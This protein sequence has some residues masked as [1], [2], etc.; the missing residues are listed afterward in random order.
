MRVLEEVLPPPGSAE[1]TPIG[2][3]QRTPKESSVYTILDPVA[4]LQ[5]FRNDIR[6]YLLLSWRAVSE[7][8]DY[9]DELGL[10]PTKAKPNSFD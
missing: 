3:L 8:W 9:R 4:Q 1:V 5:N 7:P 6:D 2:S 10:I